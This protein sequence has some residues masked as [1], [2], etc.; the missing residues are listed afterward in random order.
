MN[1]L[2]FFFCILCLI[3][4]DII[5]SFILFVFYKYFDLKYF[6]EFEIE[7]LKEENTYL[8]NENKKLS[9]ASANFWESD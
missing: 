9:G 5:V 8:K 6:S 4:F 7:K 2:L 1:G 3:S